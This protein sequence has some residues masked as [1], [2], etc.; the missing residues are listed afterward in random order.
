MLKFSEVN[1]V[2]EVEVDEIMVHYVAMK[3]D[4]TPYF[5]EGSQAKYGKIYEVVVFNQNCHTFL[6]SAS[7]AYFMMHAG[8]TVSQETYESMT[9]ED[10]D[11]MYEFFENCDLTSEDFYM[12]A[13]NVDDIMQKDKDCWVT[14]ASYGSDIPYQFESDEEA[15]SDYRSS[16]YF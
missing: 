14:L 16:P 13:Y 5:D 1:E 10:V 7:P 8:Y 6:C 9:E 15:L 12:N 4:V 2:S 3:I 11:D